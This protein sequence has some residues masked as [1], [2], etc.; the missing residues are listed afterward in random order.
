MKPSPKASAQ[1]APSPLT[2][3]GVNA[4]LWRLAKA[5]G[6]L[7][8]DHIEVVISWASAVATSAERARVLRSDILANSELKNQNQM[9]E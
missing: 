4:W 2:C 8:F 7:R 3:V 1:V 5:G 6:K 9:N